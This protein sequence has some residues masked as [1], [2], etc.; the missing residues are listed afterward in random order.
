MYIITEHKRDPATIGHTM[1]KP[2]LSTEKARELGR[3]E[4]FVGVIDDLETI[5]EHNQIYKQVM[6]EKNVGKPGYYWGRDV[7]I[8]GS[9]PM[10]LFVAAA[11]E[12]DQDPDWFMSDAKFDSYMSR[13]PEFDW[14]RS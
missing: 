13:H 12:F 2:G 14:R 10:A 7:V 9:M 6:R 4:N 11:Q 5:V 1:W 8:E 3:S